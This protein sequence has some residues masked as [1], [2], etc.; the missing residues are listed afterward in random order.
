MEEGESGIKLEL[1]GPEWQ[2]GPKRTRSTAVLAKG[3][4]GGAAHV[5]RRGGWG[6]GLS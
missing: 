4:G 3:G 5:W 6:G 1:M 2:L